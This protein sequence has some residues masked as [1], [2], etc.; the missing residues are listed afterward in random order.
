VEPELVCEV[1]FKEWTQGGSLRLPVFAR[2][3]D[4]KRPEECQRQGAE[5]PEA[6]VPAAV[7]ATPP[8][9]A[10][11]RR[12]SGS[13][14]LSNLDKVFWPEEGYTKGDLLAYYRA[15]A[16]HLLPYLKDRP[17]V[18]DRYPD[19]IAGKSFYQ[20]N[21]PAKAIEKIRTAP[22]WARGSSREIDYLLVDDLDSLLSVVNLGAIPLHIWSSRV[23]T[24]DRPDWTILDLDPKGAP[25]TS[26]VE[27]ALAIRALTEE[28]AIPSFIKTSGG[29][30]LH[31]LLPLCQQLTH[32]QSRQLAEL[33]ARV[34]TTE[35]PKIATIERTIA[36]RG[37]RVYI[38]FLQNG[39]AKLIAAPYS[40]RPLPGATV[41]TPLRWAE[42]NGNLDPK[43]FTI[44]SVPKR[45]AKMAEDPLLEVLTCRPDLGRAIER[46]A[47]RL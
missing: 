27:I 12:P 39:H 36:A 41:S 45:V 29:S 7:S 46:L 30:G 17:L 37:G 25:F 24:L 16:P 43:R 10:K 42:V 44:E 1:R 2:L 47:G 11:G 28:I 14:E 19:G 3:R 18:I 22:I 32:D 26:V 38:D 34:I 31:V 33:L 40:V 4:D 21:A 20:K 9:T 23:A 35:L 15:I 5:E 13:P 8:R 6:V